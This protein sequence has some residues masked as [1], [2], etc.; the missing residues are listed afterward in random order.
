MGLDRE[1]WLAALR[2]VRGEVEDESSG[3]ITV[4]EFAQLSRLPR[5]TAQRYLTLLTEQ[6]LAVETKRL[7]RHGNGVKVLTAYR[8][9]APKGGAACGTSSGASRRSTGSK[10]PSSSRKRRA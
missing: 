10:Q 2:A 1:G 5:P 3:A 4:T 9:T 8:L 6:G 7:A